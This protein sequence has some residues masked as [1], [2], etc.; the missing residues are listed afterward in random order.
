MV[1]VAVSAWLVLHEQSSSFCS[2]QPPGQQPSPSA[3]A[4]ICVPPLHALALQTGVPEG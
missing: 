3:H 4:V 1:G 2:V